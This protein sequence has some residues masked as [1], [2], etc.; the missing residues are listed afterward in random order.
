M[1]LL[2]RCPLF[3][4]S[5]LCGSLVPMLGKEAWYTHTHSNPELQSNLSRVF[6]PTRTQAPRG[7]M[8]PCSQ[9]DSLKSTSPPFSWSGFS[10]STGVEP[11]PHLP[12]LEARRQLYFWQHTRPPWRPMITMKTSVEGALSAQPAPRLQTGKRSHPGWQLVAQ[13]DWHAASDI[14]KE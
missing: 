12:F 2:H 8:A 11:L 4:N 3:P 6:F 13:H 5:W 14:L 1:L 7:S 10:S 9:H